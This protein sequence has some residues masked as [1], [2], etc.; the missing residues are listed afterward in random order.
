MM[1]ILERFL[2]YVHVPSA[3][4]EH[5]GKTPSDEK[6]FVLAH[7][8]MEDMKQIGITDAFVDEKCYVYGHIP[9]S[10]GYENAVRIG[11][12]AHMDTSP[13]F[14]DSPILESV[15]R[16][17]DGGDVPL[18]KS[19]RV[20]SVRD[21]PHLP[22]LQG[23]TLITTDGETLLGADDK[24]G[25][26]EILHAVDVILS[27]NIPHGPISLC[28]TP[29]E[30]IGESANAFDLGIFDAQFAYTVD[31]GT[32]GVVE[33]ETFNASAAD[34]LVRGYNIHPGDA[35][36][37]MINASLVAMEIH[38]M[39]PQEES[40]RH[41]AGYEGFYHLTD[42]E[43]DV[44]GAKLHYILRDHDAEK[45][46]EREERMR[47]AVLAVNAKY[48]E[49]TASLTIKEQYRNMAEKILP[50]YEIVE[51]ADSAVKMAGLEPTHE[52]VRGG[53]DGARLSFMGLPTPNLGTGGYSFHGPYEHITVEGMEKAAQ[54][55]VN[56]IKNCCE[57]I[58]I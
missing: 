9:P 46:K 36:D 38:S 27:E 23:K 51:I 13:D 31:G 47:R 44:S 17:Y 26:T 58:S 33:Y 41:T 7:L 1:T 37:R 6:E 28:F 2:K 55:L 56:I 21:F 29:D 22:T 42:M 30:E 50:V 4:N 53:T 57:K 20:L 3:S 40:P 15:I 14:A 18:G 35:K 54:I 32:E 24:A 43:G 12:I 49:G 34:V 48:G 45:L 11:F 5:S 19:G 25:I 8:L 52:P 16:N 39:L 10:D